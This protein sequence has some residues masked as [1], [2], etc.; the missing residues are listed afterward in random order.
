MKIA[1]SHSRSIQN[2]ILISHNCSAFSQAY[3]KVLQHWHVSLSENR[4]NIPNEIAI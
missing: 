2:P 4:V 1:V 3:P